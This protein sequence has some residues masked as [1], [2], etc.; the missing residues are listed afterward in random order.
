MEGRAGSE[1]R[2]RTRG[3]LNTTFHWPSHVSNRFYHLI[4]EPSSSWINQALTCL[5][6]FPS[7]SSLVL[8]C[9][10]IASVLSLFRHV[11]PLVPVS[12]GKST[13]LQSHENI[14]A[15]VEM[16]CR[17]I[18]PTEGV[19]RGSLGCSCATLRRRLIVL[20]PPEKTFSS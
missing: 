19:K 12:R 13:R 2:L 18:S 6:P 7:V 3:L 17:L 11:A 1:S 5:F 14:C 4:K 16:Q 20:A 8:T 10:K 9:R 15:Q